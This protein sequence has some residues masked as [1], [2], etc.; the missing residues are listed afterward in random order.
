MTRETR[1][2]YN[3][4]L[5]AAWM[6]K[7]FGMRFVNKARD[8]ELYYQPD[9]KPPFDWAPS[10]DIGCGWSGDRLYIMH[11]HFDML[12]PRIG[13]ICLI[14]YLDGSTAYREWEEYDDLPEAALDRDIRVMPIVIKRQG[15]A[16]HWPEVDA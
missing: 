6:V 1:Y 15:Y 12:K 10:S 13:D 7:Y 11:A 14:T 5:A 2:Y 9:N 3:D 8:A 16:F 4:K